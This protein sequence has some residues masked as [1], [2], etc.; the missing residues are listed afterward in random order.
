VVVTGDFDRDGWPDVATS[1]S[2]PPQA[3]IYFGVAPWSFSAPLRWSISRSGLVMHAVDMDG[4]RQLDVVVGGAGS[5]DVTILRNQGE[6]RFERFVFPV[7]FTETPFL[8][9]GC[10]DDGGVPD[11]VST[12]EGYLCTVSNRSLSPLDVD[13]NENGIPDGCE[14]EADPSLDADGDGRID[15]CRRG[16]QIVGD[17]NQ[18]GRVDIADPICL[19]RV[20]F[21]GREPLFPCEGG[22]VPGRGDIELLDSSFD[23]K[24]G[25]VDI[26]ISI[27]AL[28]TAR[29][30]PASPV[31]PGCASRC[32]FVHGCSENP[33]CEP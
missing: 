21:Q 18:D 33:G 25:L 17:C 30:A 5:R 6:R 14:L 12:G 3:L 27:E 22:E 9:V 29:P 2:E 26:I 20:L 24:L 23:D 32:R 8:L 7:G 28:F 31:A 10:F 11:I 4:D 16:R 19:A 1:T 15:A 13:C